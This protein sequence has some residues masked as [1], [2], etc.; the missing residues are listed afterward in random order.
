MG[1]ES[2]LLLD[3]WK[4]EDGGYREIPR[5][6]KRSPK[7]KLAVF[8]AVGLLF[9]LNSP[10]QATPEPTSTI[11]AL[12]YKVMNERDFERSSRIRSP[13]VVAPKPELVRVPRWDSPLS[14]DYQITSCYA[15]RWGN[16]HYGIDMAASYGTTIKSVGVGKVIQ[17]GWY[18]DYG[19]SVV[20]DHGDG[21]LTVYAHTSTVF[22]RVGQR[23]DKSQ[24]IANIGST[25]YS[26]GPHLHFGVALNH[27]GNWVDPIPWLSQR[28]VR[29]NGC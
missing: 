26:T 9:L 13:E 1:K 20:I 6:R 4:P 22:V 29:I 23:V 25:G 21:W 14:S 10:D 16:M 19:I 15:Y 12:V 28:G 27:F 7:T 8:T 3:Y 18:G 5:H 11:S 24:H 2:D 17:A